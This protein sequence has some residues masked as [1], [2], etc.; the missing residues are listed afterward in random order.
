M[1]GVLCACSCFVPFSILV[2]LYE[3]RAFLDRAAQ[4]LRN[5]LFEDGM[6]YDGI[7]SSMFVPFETTTGKAR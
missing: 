6:V 5:Y 3:F 1:V 4:V 7:C 2:R